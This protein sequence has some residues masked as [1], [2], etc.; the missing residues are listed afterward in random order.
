MIYY[1]SG[2]S[3]QH[4]RDVLTGLYEST[5]GAELPPVNGAKV[6]PQN[7]GRFQFHYLFGDWVLSPGFWTGGV[8][9]PPT[10]KPGYHVAIGILATAPNP[11][12]VIGPQDTAMLEAAGISVL[13]ETELS[14]AQ[15]ALLPKFQ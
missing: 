10:L 5:I 14:A 2:Q 13:D 6:V 8:W 3:E 1:L 15:L 9:T 4:V 12:G 7:D 11:Q